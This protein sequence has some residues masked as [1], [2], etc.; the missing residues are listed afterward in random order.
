MKSEKDNIMQYHLMWNLNYGTND[1]IYK[2]ETDH[3]LGEQTCSCQGEGGRS[4]MNG[5][6][7]VRG[8]KHYIWSG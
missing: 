5:E 7:E 3:R 2:T 4:G 1:P 8:C 6:F